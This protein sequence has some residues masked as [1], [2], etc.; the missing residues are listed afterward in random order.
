MKS[1]S[2]Y[3]NFEAINDVFVFQQ[4][5]FSDIAYAHG[6]STAYWPNP[7]YMVTLLFWCLSAVQLLVNFLFSLSLDYGDGCAIPG[8]IH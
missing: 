2:Q 1:I 6:I 3:T 7:Q 5:L 4:L 8:Q